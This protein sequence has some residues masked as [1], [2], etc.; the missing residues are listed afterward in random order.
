M[1]MPHDVLIFGKGGVQRFYILDLVET[2][3]F[4]VGYRVITGNIQAKKYCS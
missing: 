4:F 1:H 2:K 3:Y